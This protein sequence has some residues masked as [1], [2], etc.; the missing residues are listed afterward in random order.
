[1]SSR[2]I[3]ALDVPTMDL[4]LSWCDRLPEVEFW[5]VGLELFTA[6][7]PA[8][9]EALKLRQ[10][11]VFLDLKLHD[12]PQTVAR[13]CERLATYGVDL[14]TVHS[15]GGK[16]MMTAAVQS[17]VG[18]GTQVLAVSLLTSISPTQ[19]ASE[20]QIDLGV[21]DYVVRMATLAEQSGVQGIV[22]SGEEIALL[23]SQLSSPLLLVTPGIR[24]A[25]D[26]VGD[27]KRVVTPQQAIALGADY[28][29]IGR[30]ILAAA[31]PHRAWRDCLK[32][33]S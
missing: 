31:D 9:I 5:K 1:M 29:V 4:A 20:L 7:G 24:L 27:Q 22:C 21:G 15:C 13:T 3:V 26:Q 25:H 8:V 14:M 16:E 11:R 12:I 30:S 18:T 10:K 33:I 17:L 23:R 2:V 19:L 32:Q 28:L 6:A